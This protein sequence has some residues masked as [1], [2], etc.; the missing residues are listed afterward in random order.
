MKLDLARE[1]LQKARLA[2][3]AQDSPLLDEIDTISRSLNYVSGRVSA[4]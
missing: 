4:N 1:H 2:A 3:A